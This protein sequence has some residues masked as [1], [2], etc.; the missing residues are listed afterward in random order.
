MTIARI[1]LQA[2]RLAVISA[3]TRKR[4]FVSLPSLVLLSVRAR[5]AD[6]IASIDGAFGGVALAAASSRDR[7]RGARENRR[8]RS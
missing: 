6:S 2:P 3:P 8:L 4:I 5:L 7:E 1:F